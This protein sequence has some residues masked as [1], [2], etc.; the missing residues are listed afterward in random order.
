MTKT[1]RD[2]GVAASEYPW[3]GRFI[4][5]DGHTMHVLDVGPTEGAADEPVLMVHG[6]P[7]WS[8]YWRH[9]VSALSGTHRCIVP[10]HIGMGLSDKPADDAYPYT[11]AR[12]VSDL[13]KVVDSLYPSGKLTLAVHDWGG[14]IGM[15]WAVQNPDR[16]ARIVV[17]NTSAFMPNDDIKLP[18]QLKLARSPLGTALV[19]G[20][21]AFAIGATVTCTE[22]P[23]SSA[24]KKGYTAPYDTFA[25]RIATLR[26]V[27]DIPL[28]PKDG[29]WALVEATDA[30]LDLFAQTPI[31][32]LWGD[33]DYVFH[34]GFRAQ[35]EKRWPH[36]EVQ[37]WPA[38]H[39]VI[40][41]EKEA[42]CS[43]IAAF[44]G[45]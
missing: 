37:S 4:D 23:L 27:Q 3:T 35:F 11:L 36:A 6:N 7:T 14:M 20:F 40:E 25:N 16:V 30:G 32:V 15:A 24:A 43:K 42:V 5:I 22:K 29:A 1:A 45:A 8:F 34:P 12:R 31:L 33:K 10:D 2:I 38:G 39:F 21:N 41:D 19:Q 26:F 17:T 44:V 9:L 18:W 13:T 28:S